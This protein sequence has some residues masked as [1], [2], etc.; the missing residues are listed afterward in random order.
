MVENTPRARFPQTTSQLPINAG[1]TVLGSYIR[2]NTV[3]K[4]MNRPIS[5]SQMTVLVTK[6]VKKDERLEPIWS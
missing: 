3:L 5:M 2:L 4:T 6:D 1:Y